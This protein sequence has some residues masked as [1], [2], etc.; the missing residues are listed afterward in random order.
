MRKNIIYRIPESSFI[1]IFCTFEFILHLISHFFNT[2][3]LFYLFSFFFFFLNLF[4]LP[5]VLYER[6]KF[7]YLV[8][9]L[10][11]SIFCSYDY[12]TKYIINLLDKYLYNKM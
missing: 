6:L 2:V 5:H 11:S 9:K 10:I 8:L 4:F 7:I 12:D 1:P 3:N